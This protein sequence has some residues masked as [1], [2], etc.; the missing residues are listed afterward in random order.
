VKWD[1][2]KVEIK[3]YANIDSEI[4]LRYKEERQEL[5]VKNGEMYTIFM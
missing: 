1:K 4:I 2:N 3:I 5:T